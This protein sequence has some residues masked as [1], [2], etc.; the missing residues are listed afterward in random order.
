MKV[1][2]HHFETIWIHPGNQLII[3]IIDQRFLPFEFIIED[4]HNEHEMYVAIKDMHL[5]GAPLIGAAGAMGMYL[6]VAC[7]K[8]ENITAEFV[9]E[10]AAWLKTSRPTAVNLCWGVDK[11]KDSLLGITDSKAIIEKARNSALAVIDEERRNCAKIGEYGIKIIEEISRRKGGD[12]VNILTHCNAGWLACIDFGTATAPIYFAHD[13]GIKVHVWVDETRPRNQGSKLTAWEL[14]EHGVPCTVIA[15]NT[16]GHLMQNGLV[17]MVIVGSDRASPYGDVINKIGT[18][19]K[20]L[21]AKDNDIPFY[22]ALPSSTID[23]HL[24]EGGMDTPIEERSGSEVRIV[25]GMVDEKIREVEIIPARIP[26]ANYAFDVTP[27]RLV[28]G[29]ITERG[30]SNAD[31]KSIFTLFPEQNLNPIA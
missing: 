25:D 7:C 17:D 29:I 10:K 23:W 28:S 12:T 20:A 18:Y 9:Q 1:K 30:I 21:A 16:G 19:L 3:Q 14:T 13:K 6:S 27:A 22:A 24:K 31:K 26:V 11:V 5:R 15:D 2:G 4:I 8:A